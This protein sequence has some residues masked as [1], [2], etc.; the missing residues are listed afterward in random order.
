[1]APSTTILLYKHL[2]SLDCGTTLAK[3]NYVKNFRKLKI[4]A[5]LI[6][7]AL[8]GVMTINLFWAPHALAG[9]TESKIAQQSAEIAIKTTTV[10]AIDKYAN[11][12]LNI[13]PSA[14]AYSPIAQSL[15]VYNLGMSLKSF[16]EADSD[17]GRLFAAMDTA[18][19]VAMM[20]NP[21]LGVIV[22]LAVLA[23]KMIDANLSIEHQKRM[24][25]I[26]KKIKEYQEQYYSD[27]TK[28]MGAEKHQLNSA[29]DRLNYAMSS[30]STLQPKI[31]N[32]C[33]SVNGDSGYESF[34]LCFNN[35]RV[36]LLHY[37]QFNE[38]A[39]FII[40]YKNDHFDIDIIMK[41][42]KISK[43]SLRKEV[44]ENLSKIS[45]LEKMLDAFEEYSSRS[46]AK[47][48]QE[49]TE[50][51]ALLSTREAFYTSCLND[52]VQL[53]AASIQRSILKTK[54]QRKSL[55]QSDL[56]RNSESLIRLISL[57]EEKECFEIVKADTNLELIGTMLKGRSEDVS[58]ISKKLSV[59]GLK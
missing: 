11:A 16:A 32:Q 43:E 46:L 19:S 6:K 41:E 31:L 34:D 25:E 22:Q 28:T 54:A 29:F 5:R 55:V 17:K 45:M 36:L 37:K 26:L 2:F 42:L 50:Q 14:V 1:M 56:L 58:R 49:Q 4:T 35:L 53:Q 39:Q 8:C 13:N 47:T 7:L 20:I 52:V 3:P 9:E 18:A 44:H 30:I 27:L 57:V 10:D 48:I 23:V 38:S 24:L 59:E 40:E 15:A 12:T 21:A 33:G 51:A